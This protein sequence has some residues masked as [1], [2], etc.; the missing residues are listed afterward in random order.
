M[1]ALTLA[2]GVMTTLRV[3]LALAY[4]RYTVT[5]RH[6]EWAGGVFSRGKHLIPLAA[7]RD[8]SSFATYDQRLLGLGDVTVVATYGSGITFHD[9]TDHEAKCEAIWHLVRK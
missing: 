7:I 6:I 2:G 5:T 1:F 4:T 3:N 8:V 9:V